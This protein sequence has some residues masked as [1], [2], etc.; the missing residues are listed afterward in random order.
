MMNN[1]TISAIDISGNKNN[2]YIK[3]KNEESLEIFIYDN[4]EFLGECF[5]FKVIRKGDIF[6]VQNMF[7]YDIKYR[8]QGLPEAL[9]EYAQNYLNQPIYSS[10]IVQ[11]GND[12]LSEEGKKV[13]CRMVSNGKAVFDQSR[14]R[15]VSI[16]S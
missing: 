16:V 6:K 12:W 1:K 4:Q 14:N 5:E 3:V 9:I 8:K 2:F 10:S 11:E 13:W 15:Y 7:A